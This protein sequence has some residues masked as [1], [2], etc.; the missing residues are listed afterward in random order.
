MQA[1]LMYGAGDVRVEE[2]PDPVRCS[3]PSAGATCGPTGRCRPRTTAAAWGTSSSVSSRTS[4]ARSP[5]SPVGTSCSRPSCGATTP[6]TS[7]GQV[8]PPRAATAEAGA[9]TSTAA[10]ARRCAS[11]RRREPWC[12]SAVTEDSAL[13]PALL[14]LSDVLCTGHHAAVTARVDQ[15]TSVTVIG[16]GAV[17]LSAVIAAKR[18][19]AERIVLMGRHTD[20]T[21]LGRELG[22]TDV[23]AARGDEGVEA[24]R[25][26]TGGDGTHAV[27]ECVAPPS[28][29][30][31]HS[32][33]SATAAPS[34][35]SGC[36]ST[37]T[38]PWTSAP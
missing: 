8:S 24:V 4:A 31:R 34:A 14:T 33:S 15:H 19:G 26:P 9:T 17:G 6:V 13:L 29:W 37:P 11:R 21:S 5:D 16:D 32:R 25:E 36:L 7:A 23:V 38:S 20:R 35:A 1:T 2:V 28:P 12:G 10:R 30:R 18:L 27:L 22:A 3:A